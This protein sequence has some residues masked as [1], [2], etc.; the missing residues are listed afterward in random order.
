MNMINILEIQFN[1]DWK[2]TKLRVP[3]IYGPLMKAVAKLGIYNQVCSREVVWGRALA[4]LS[5]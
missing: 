3:S 5:P 2:I 4:N 1:G